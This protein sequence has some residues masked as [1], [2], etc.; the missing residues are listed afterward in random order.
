[1]AVVFTK[2]RTLAAVTSDLDKLLYTMKTLHNA[3]ADPIEWPEFWNEDW[4]K[5][6]M[7]E[8]DRRN[9]A[10]EELLQYEMTLARNA[11]IV[12]NARL[13]LEKATQD[14]LDQGREEGREEAAATTVRN[15]LRMQVLTTA[16]IAAA[17]GVAIAFVEDIQQEGAR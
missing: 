6:A 10:P 2:A 14:G 5:V 4:I 9:M 8:L 7:Q 13:Q 17:A 12:N 15:L 11:H 16:Q 3:P 1:M